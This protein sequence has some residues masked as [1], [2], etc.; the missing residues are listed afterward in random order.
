[1]VGRASLIHSL[2]QRDHASKID[3]LA[4]Q[5]GI[6]QDVLIEV[7]NGEENKQG[8]ADTELLDMLMACH[9]LSHLRVVGLMIMAPQGSRERAQAA[10]DMLATLR[11]T[12]QAQLARQGVHDINLRELSMGMSEDYREAIPRGATMVRIGRA[13]F[14]D[15]HSPAFNLAQR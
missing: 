15:N 1:M 5:A 9:E 13:I 10:F 6:V 3:R 11:D 7:N 14:S 8:L 2:Y 4:A 12:T